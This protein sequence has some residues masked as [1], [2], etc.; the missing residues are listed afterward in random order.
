MSTRA[1]SGLK[2]AD[3]TL[4]ITGSA[5]SLMKKRLGLMGATV[6]FTL[7]F[8]IYWLRLDNVVGACVDDGWYVL[9]AKALAS[10][11]SY[12]LINSPTPGIMPIY[13]PGFPWLLSLVFRL[14]PNFPENIWLLKMVS[15]TAIFGV[16][17]ASYQLFKRE[18]GWPRYV[19]LLAALVVVTAP[20]FVFLATSTAM[21][22]PVFTLSQLLAVLAIERAVRGCNQRIAMLYILS[23]AVFAS[24]AFLTRSIAIV[25]IGAAVIYLLKERLWRLAAVFVL[26]VTVLVFPWM[27]YARLHAPTLAEKKEQGN[28]IVESYGEQFWSKRAGV[29]TTGRITVRDLPERVWKNLV[30]IFGRDIGGMF[31]PQLYRP[32]SESGLEIIELG[33]SLGRVMLNMGATT[34]TMIFSLLISLI[35]SIG[36]I[37]R[38]RSRIKLAELVVVFSLGMIVIWLGLFRFVLPLMPFIVLYFIDGLKHL[39]QWFVAVW[40]KSESTNT[41]AAARM[42]IVCVLAFNVYEHFSYIRAGQSNRANQMWL[43]DYDEQYEVINWVAR[44]LPRE[45]IIAT[46][47]PPLINLLTGHKTVGCNEPIRNLE[48]WQRLGVRYIVY[49]AASPVRESDQIEQH[50]QVIYRSPSTGLRVLAINPPNKN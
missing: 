14:V 1:T 34:G 44:E 2:N 39:S 24:F 19:A 13:P 50:S 7:C 26:G 35:A 17:A 40:Q 27:V 42:L 48:N 45:A 43:S 31:L 41:W 30:D 18:G 5:H 46:S 12:T 32:A 9:L 16:G 15:V 28:Y 10:G 21:S 29:S 8:V 3:E 33:G 6:S 47:N 22:E 38:C 36:F 25:M 37:T 20:G 4:L 49:L 23:G 11:Q